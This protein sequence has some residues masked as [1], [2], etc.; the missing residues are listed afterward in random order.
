MEGEKTRGSGEPD[1][2]RLHIDRHPVSRLTYSWTRPVIEQAR[3]EVLSSRD[4]GPPPDWVKTESLTSRLDHFRRRA[5]R[6]GRGWA[7]TIFKLCQRDMIRGMSFSGLAEVLIGCYP[8]LFA[9]LMDNLNKTS[10]GQDLSPWETYGIAAALLG[11]QLLRLFTV[12]YCASKMFDLSYMTRSALIG[13]IY[14]K[15]VRLGNG[16]RQK[17]LG[18]RGIQVITADTAKICAAMMITNFVWIIPVRTAAAFVYAYCHF[19]MYALPA[20]AVVTLVIP[21]LYWIAQIIR[22]KSDKLAAVTDDRIGATQEA[23]ENIKVVKYLSLEESSIAKVEAIRKR[24]LRLLFDVNALFSLALA[25]DN[26]APIFASALA[27]ACYEL[28]STDIQPGPAFSLIQAF[29]YLALPLWVLPI[30]V[31]GAIKARG[32]LARIDQFLDSEESESSPSPLCGASATKQAIVLDNATFQWDCPPPDPQSRRQR[33]RIEK[34]LVVPEPVPR[35]PFR[36]RAL[37]LAIPEGSLVGVIGKSGAGKSS[38]LYALL[39]EMKHTSGSRCVR[40]SLSICEQSAWLFQGTI[41]DNIL[42]GLPFEESRYRQVL[43]ECSLEDDLS[44]FHRG[45]GTVVGERG[46]SVSGGQRQRIGLARAAYAQAEIV[47]LDDPLSAVDANVARHLFYRC[48]KRGILATKTRI[49]TTHHVGYLSDCDMILVMEEGRVIASGTYSQ[50]LSLETEEMSRFRELLLKSPVQV[51]PQDPAPPAGPDAHDTDSPPTYY[52]STQDQEGYREDV[53]RSAGREAVSIY[54]RALRGWKIV[55]LITLLAIATEVFNTCKEDLLRQRMKS[56]TSTSLSTSPLAPFSSASI[57]SSIF[58]VFTLSTF[59]SRLVSNFAFQYLLLASLHGLFSTLVGIGA[60][61]FCKAASRTIH[62]ECF[63]RVMDARLAVFDATPIGRLLNR[64]G[65][66]MDFIDANFPD[67]ITQFLVS[68]S[69]LLSTVI[70][71]GCYYPRVLLSIV[72]PLCGTLVVHQKFRRTWRQLQ[73]ISGIS[74]GPIV[75]HFSESLTGLTTIRT[76]GQ[77]DQF[78]K[79]FDVHTDV[80]TYSAIWLMSVRRWASLRTETLWIV[81]WGAVAMYFI[82]QRQPAETVGPILRYIMST[83]ESVDFSMRHLAELESCLVSVERLHLY[84]HQL[85]SDHQDDHASVPFPAAWPNEGRVAFANVSVRYKPTLP[86]VLIDFTFTFPPKTRVAIVGRSG[87]GKSTIL[88]ALFR[89][90]RLAAGSITID[91]VDISRLSVKAL[92]RSLA[93]VPQDP[94]LFS[95][96]LRSNLDPFSLN[97]DAQIWRAL[98]SV[99]LKDSIAQHPRKLDMLIDKAGG[100]FSIG[101]RQLL[102]LARA[103]LKGSRIIVMD[104]ATSNLDRETEALMQQSLEETF[105]E[106]TII[107]IAHRLETVM[108]YDLIVVMGG[109]RILEAGNPREL[110]RKGEGEFQRMLKSSALDLT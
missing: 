54:V 95:G 33:R 96:T 107:T 109:G 39:G 11:V 94:V 5:K 29:G 4:L 22:R 104:E 101:Q 12:S 83:I 103:V 63:E 27:I 18:G 60:V 2:I 49:L 110:A 26:W 69:S 61:W 99:H 80:L 13:T 28:H 79:T 19:G 56:S 25:I 74:V 43:R 67:R 58:S 8:L 87:A 36:L 102:C 55:M 16:P 57:I 17:Y 48:I 75:S 81:Y 68:I 64:F 45:D 52:S 50:L 76:F 24:E 46:A 70:L 10:Q 97:S 84:V 40:G 38:L 77:R 91:G 78:I 51:E 62:R 30:L 88:A 65:R 1:R 42:F 31:G 35:E 32:S 23:F 93:M 53:S 9:R 59:M 85:E 100:D 66:D 6:E 47:L 7:W 44:G 34:G 73:Q 86:L 15:S 90:T 71:L 92:R 20:I 3:H 82:W 37:S 105:R 41:R 98:E 14:R 106:A 21:A 72:L 89:F 108:H